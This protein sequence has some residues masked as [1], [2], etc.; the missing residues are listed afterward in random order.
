M[1]K[2]LFLYKKPLEKYSFDIAEKQD[3]EDK[4]I[5]T[6]DFV[7]EDVLKNLDYVKD[8]FSCDKNG[9][10]VIREFDVNV[11]GKL[12]KSFLVCVDG[13]VGSA[14]INENILMPL[15]YLSDFKKREK[16]ND[17]DYSEGGLILG[18]QS[19]FFKS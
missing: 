10:V 19:Y 14:D 2:E 7:S 6:M 4:K 8:V 11:D 3:E 12:L 5:K 1:F 17:E 13:L 16:E 15:M 18:K 9:D